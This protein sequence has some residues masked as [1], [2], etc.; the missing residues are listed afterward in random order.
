MYVFR[1][2]SD[3]TGS[4]AFTVPPIPSAHPRK[5]RA[6]PRVLFAAVAAMFRATASWFVADSALTLAIS[7]KAPSALQLGIP[8]GQTSE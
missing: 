7:R 6:L 5:I 8:G 3:G 2:M 4:A 1:A